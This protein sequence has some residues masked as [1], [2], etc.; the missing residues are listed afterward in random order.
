M[1]TKREPPRG[2]QGFPR[3][4]P[5]LKKKPKPKAKAPRKPA[6]KTALEAELRRRKRNWGDGN[7]EQRR[8]VHRSVMSHDYRV[9]MRRIAH[10]ELGFQELPGGD[11]A[12]QK[13]AHR[14]EDDAI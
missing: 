13:T 8:H 9:T 6:W 14:R 11:G 3:K 1:A 10:K 4:S 2:K 5:R 12:Y 7:G